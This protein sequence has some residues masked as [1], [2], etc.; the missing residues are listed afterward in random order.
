MDETPT[1]A[2]VRR[3][4]VAAIYS[5]AH[6]ID[7][8]VRRGAGRDILNL[9]SQDSWP[10]LDD[11]DLASLDFEAPLEV[12]Y[13]YA[14][15]AEIGNTEI[16]D[17]WEEGNLGRFQSIVRLISN[18]LFDLNEQEVWDLYSDTR[19]GQGSFR[20]MIRLATARYHLDHDSVSLDDVMVL[21]D[22][23]ERSVRNAL[24]SEGI[25]I[26]KKV[27]GNTF[28]GE[29]ISRQQIL[30][31]LRSR[32]RFMETKQIGSLNPVP[33]SL[34]ADEIPAFIKQQA[35]QT[36]IRRRMTHLVQSLTSE[37]QTYEKSAAM[38]NLGKNVGW[39]EEKVAAL[40]QTSSVE[41]I[42]PD[43][44]PVI[45]RMLGLDAQWWT[46][47][48]MRARFPEAMK[49]IAPV[50][51]QG[52]PS[53]SLLNEE[54]NTLDVVLTAAGIRNGYFD[55]ERRYADR[56][57]PADSFGTKGA[58]RFGKE[59]LLHHDQKK[60]PYQTDIRIKSHALASPRKRF[61]AY[62]TAHNAKPGD[63]IRIKRLS[64]REYRL[65]F[66]PQ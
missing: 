36:L 24:K 57:F 13:R 61:S 44:C 56:F 41:E 37:E 52:A 40:L 27:I 14:F 28:L 23:E 5:I 15:Y 43:D 47:Q 60:S 12:I 19:A 58:E 25:T 1:F 55:I 50:M 9:S 63:V 59:V 62:F 3:D 8:H 10:N 21:A 45:A 49:E 32:R 65:T 26:H 4:F 42:S 66:Q 34:E 16:H 17:D 54:E 22:M 64:E 39:T 35:K 31:W 7:I 6:T 2:E 51:I 46:D 29:Y 38:F 30:P 33:D 11:F 48:V 53:P 18:D 20:K